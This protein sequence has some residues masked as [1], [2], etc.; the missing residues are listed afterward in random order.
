MD[1]PD[2]FDAQ[3]DEEG[4]LIREDKDGNPI[5]YKEVDL[6]KVLFNHEQDCEN[7]EMWEDMEEEDEEDYEYEGEGTMPTYSPEEQ[8]YSTFCFNGDKE[9]V[10]NLKSI[11]PIIEECGCDINWNGKGD[12]RPTI[13][14]EL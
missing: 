8:D 9:G 2:Y 3:Y 4:Y 11:I 13:S 12:Q 7:E 10:K 5:E 14:W 1:I 6:S